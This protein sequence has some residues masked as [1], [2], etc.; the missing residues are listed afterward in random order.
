VIRWSLVGVL[1]A[2]AVTP[3]AVM[4]WQLLAVLHLAVLPVVL[5]GLD[6]EA[7][8][9][10][11]SVLRGASAYACLCLVLIVAIGWGSPMFRCGGETCEAMNATPPPLRADH[12]MLEALGIQ[13]TCRYEVNVPG[14]WWPDVL[15]EH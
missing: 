1:I 10:R 6:L 13:A 2:C 11:L 5:L 15:P 12:E 9:R 14:G 8:G 7:R 4:S 3:T